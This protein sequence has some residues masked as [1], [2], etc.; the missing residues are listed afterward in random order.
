MEICS[1]VELKSGCGIEIGKKDLNSYPRIR[2]RKM[3]A[4]ANAKLELRIRFDYEFVK[5]AGVILFL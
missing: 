3:K 5:S 1:Q 4:F 2:I